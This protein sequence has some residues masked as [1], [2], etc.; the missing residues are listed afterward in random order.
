[1]PAARK[2]PTGKVPPDVLRR[3]VFPYLGVKS[4]RV[5]QGPGVGEDAAVIDMGDRVVIAKA[6][7]ITG[8]EAKIGW[9]AVH[10]NA[11][12]VAACG[13]RPQWFLSI[14]LLPEGADESLLE[15]IMKDIHEACSDLGISLIGG[16]T[17][18]T[19]G[20]DKPIVAGF[21]MGELSRDKFVTTGGAK[22][23]DLIVMT[24]GAGI[25]GTGILATDLSDKLLSEVDREVLERA[26]ELLKKISVVQEALT[27]VDIGGVH[28][29]HTPTE[30]GVMNGI[31]EM[32]EAA[33][34]GV[35][36]HEDAI[37]ISEETIA[38]CNALDADPLKLMG[39]GALIIV[40][41]PEKTGEVITKIRDTGVAASVIGKIMPLDE[42]RI[43]VKKDESR[44]AI[45]AVDQDEVYRLLEKYSLDE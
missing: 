43:L 22:P 4:N 31:W 1:M 14:V 38:I 17:E 11:N 15:G 33:G 3:V 16:H 8:A 41:E 5:L 27:A 36:V 18:S 10:I 34:V 30:G 6:N 37:K 32:T 40:I 21:M 45:E 42:G 19:P 20:L 2:L 7:P 24:K 35:E 13:A 28:S 25:E 9:L 26:T 39:S 23:G 44:V 29:L 12:D